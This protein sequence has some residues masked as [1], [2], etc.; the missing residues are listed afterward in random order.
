MAT[1]TPATA[2]APRGRAVTGRLGV[3]RRGSFD[4]A[5]YQSVL[6]KP[7]YHR[8]MLNTLVLGALAAIS[9][10]VAG[11]LYAYT[12]VRARLPRPL[13]AYLRLMALLPIIS[14]PFALAL[15]TILLFGRSGLI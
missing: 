2:F 11:F 15:A 10:T 7:V 13:A 4:L 5:A 1:L 9:G 14:P 8:V 3:F 6:A 12:L